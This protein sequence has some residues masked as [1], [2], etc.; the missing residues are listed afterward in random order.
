MPGIM[1][2]ETLM[3]SMV[4]CTLQ[5]TR[6]TTAQL[7]RR[8]VANDVFFYGSQSVQELMTLISFTLAVIG[9]GVDEVA[10][11]AM[12]SEYRQLDTALRRHRIVRGAEW[13]G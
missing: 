12:L 10:F 9:A 11:N 1:P 8:S 6:N 13:D 5:A 7:E 3:E 4:A 2:S